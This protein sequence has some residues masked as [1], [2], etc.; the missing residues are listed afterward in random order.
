M[1]RRNYKNRESENEDTWVC[2]CECGRTAV[3]SGDDLRSG[4]STG[5]SGTAAGCLEDLQPVP[6]CMN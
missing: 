1:K 3:V 6:S 4:R 2:R 5:C